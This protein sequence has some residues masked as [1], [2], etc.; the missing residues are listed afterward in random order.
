MKRSEAKV[1][2]G[3]L[4]LFIDRKRSWTKRKF[5]TIGLKAKVY[6]PIT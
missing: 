4:A 5:Q 3:K 1:D 2:K 6:I